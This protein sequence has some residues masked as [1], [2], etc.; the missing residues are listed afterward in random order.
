MTLLINVHCQLLSN[1]IFFN[2]TQLAHLGYSYENRDFLLSPLCNY[3]FANYLMPTDDMKNGEDE[4]D[5][6]ACK[7]LPK[8]CP[9]MLLQLN[10]Y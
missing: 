8:Q 4:Y 9:A 10:H 3:A 1:S 7:S 5:V 6:C 2:I